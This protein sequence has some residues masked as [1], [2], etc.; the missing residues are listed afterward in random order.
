MIEPVAWQFR[1]KP[2]NASW[3]YC[4]KTDAAEF[5]AIGDYE[6]RPLYAIPEGYKVVPVEPTGRCCGLGAK[7][8][9]NT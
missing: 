8:L 3:N 1:H 2:T 6:T 4:S 9:A 7:C 5:A